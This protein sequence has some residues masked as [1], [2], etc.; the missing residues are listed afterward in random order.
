VSL[1]QRKWY[2]N[3]IVIDHPVARILVDENGNTNLPMSKSDQSTSVFDLGIR[4]VM[5]G[6]GEVYY[7]DRKSVLDADLHDVE[8]QAS[9]DP[10][11]KQY[12]G[13]LSYENGQIHLQDLNPMVHSPPGGVRRDPRHIYSETEHTHQRRV[14]V[15]A[16]SHAERLRSSQGKRQISG[17]A[18]HRRTPA[19]IERRNTPRWSRETGGIGAVRERSKQDGS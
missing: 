3:D 10:A 8:F 11:I 7:N 6:K 9:F 15:L 1:L 5:V 14:P 16:H 12:S 4:H 2:L 18:R 19:D 13:G 17:V